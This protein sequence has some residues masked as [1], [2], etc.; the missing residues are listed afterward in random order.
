MDDRF[1]RRELLLHLGDMLQAARRSNLRRGPD[2]CTLS[3]SAVISP[4]VS[5]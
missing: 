5:K 1:D 4:E 2:L 3:T